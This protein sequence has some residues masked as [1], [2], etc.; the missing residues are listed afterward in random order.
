MVGVETD[1]VGFLDRYVTWRQLLIDNEE[2]REGVV[3]RR[4][5]RVRWWLKGS[6]E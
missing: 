2:N 1:R 5:L 4:R 6:W 3:D